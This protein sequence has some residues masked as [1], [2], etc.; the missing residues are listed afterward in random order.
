[1]DDLKI[2]SKD[3]GDMSSSDVSVWRHGLDEQLR[4]VDLN[5]SKI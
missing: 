5:H 1:M 3:N 4:N 2:D